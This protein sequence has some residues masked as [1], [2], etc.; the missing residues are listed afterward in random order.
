MFLPSFDENGIGKSQAGRTYVNMTVIVKMM[1]IITC[2]Y[3]YMCEGVTMIIYW[4]TTHFD[5]VNQAD[6]GL[7]NYWKNSRKEYTRSS[8][9]R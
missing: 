3:G 6:P 2:M 1:S 8:C 9:D 7:L 5:K 4:L